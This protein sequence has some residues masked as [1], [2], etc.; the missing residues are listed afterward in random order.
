VDP[1]TL[2]ILFGMQGANSLVGAYTQSQAIKAQAGYAQAMGERNARLAEMQA[3]DALRRG[4]IDAARVRREGERFVGGQR[5]A[6]SASG[7]DVNYGSAAEL[8]SE[9]KYLSEEDA[10]MTQNNAWREALGF[11]S[12][13]ND[14]RSRG[15]VAAMQGR[16]EARNT[17][18]T[19]GLKF[20]QSGALAAYSLDKGGSPKTPTTQATSRI[21]IE[22]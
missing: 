8:Q 14:Y 13:A 10:R 11:K 2:A 17:L 20:L 6:L 3:D 21:P 15:R 5:A 4:N 7:I 16:F 12:Q 22:D 18:L 1:T 19:G 9:T